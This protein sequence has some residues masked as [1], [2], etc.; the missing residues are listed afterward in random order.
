MKWKIF[1]RMLIVINNPLVF[2]ETGQQHQKKYYFVNEIWESVGCCW[3]QG[4]HEISAWGGGSGLGLKQPDSVSEASIPRRTFTWISRND[5]LFGP[6]QVSRL[7]ITFVHSEVP[8]I[9]HF[10]HLNVS[11]HFLFVLMSL[12]GMHTNSYVNI[13]K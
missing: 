4:L 8:L 1:M 3:Y 13:F 10:Y 5:I 2:F 12:S 11:F 9:H 7:P 6:E